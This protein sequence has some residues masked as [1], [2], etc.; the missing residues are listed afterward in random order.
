LLLLY[1][2]Y[3]YRTGEDTYQN[4]YIIND[5]LFAGFSLALVALGYKRRVHIDVLERIVFALLA[6]ES[7]IF[8]TLAPYLFSFDLQRVFDE[9]VVDDV[10]LLILVCSL[11]LHIF[12]RGHG[13][14]LAAGLYATSLAVTSLYL[15]THLGNE[16]R[17]ASL[18]LQ[19]YLAGGMV[20]CFIY[21]LARYRSSVKRISVQYEM[22]EQ[23]AFLDAL[24]GLPNRRCMYDVLQQQLELLERYGTSFCIALLDIDHF[25]RVNDT[26]GHLKGDNVL[27]QVSNALRNELRTTDQL[28]R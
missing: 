3:V 18:T 12:Q 4:V 27:V 24:T 11:A 10:W 26:F 14:A 13:L 15:V 2:I 19:T 16:T 21:V 28:G 25:K 9:T 23:I 1:D 6:L 5:A 8:N 17:L 20:L 7:F 22:L